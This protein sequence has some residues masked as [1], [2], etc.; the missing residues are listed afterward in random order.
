MPP[1]PHLTPLQRWLKK[2]GEGRI[3]WLARLIGTTRA[4]CRTY[5]FRQRMP[6]AI[7]LERLRLVTGLSVEQLSPPHAIRHRRRWH[8]SA[9]FAQFM[10]IE[11]ER[12]ERER[13]KRA[14][15]AKRAVEPTRV[16]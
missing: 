7:V 6:D 1:T 9:A 14:K 10:E 15:R 8:A 13:K 12:R 3:L 11:E 4:S 5:V 2:H 16:A